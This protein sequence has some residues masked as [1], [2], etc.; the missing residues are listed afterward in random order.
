[1][2][3]QAIHVLVMEPFSLL[4]SYFENSKQTRKI[5]YDTLFETNTL[6]FKFPYLLDYR[7]N[8][9]TSIS[10]REVFGRLAMLIFYG[11]VGPILKKKSNTL[12]IS[13]E[14]RMH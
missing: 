4:V 8:A 12:D 7:N 14:T 10:L 1:M 9:V 2:A 11:H 6:I 3:T 5:K 13:T